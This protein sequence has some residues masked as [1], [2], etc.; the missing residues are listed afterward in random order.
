MLAIAVESDE[1]SILMNVVQ[2]WLL[3][4]LMRK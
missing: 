1:Q 2:K 4:T 3:S